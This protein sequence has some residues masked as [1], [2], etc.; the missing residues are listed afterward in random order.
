MLKDGGIYIEFENI[1]PLTQRG[2]EIGLHMWKTF[3]IDNGKT[4]TQAA[5]HISRF[6][7]SYFPI[8]IPDH[9]ALLKTRDSPLSKYFGPLSCRPV[10]MR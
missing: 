2:Q 10:S 5:D 4:P 8:S 3:Q 1:R 7:T 6:D 9:L